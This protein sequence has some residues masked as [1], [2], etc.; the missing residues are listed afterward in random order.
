[1]YA[2]TLALLGF[3]GLASAASNLPD[4]TNCGGAYYSSD[5]IATAINAAIDDNNSGNRPDN[6]EL[7]WSAMVWC[8]AVTG[9][10]M[11]VRWWVEVPSGGVSSLA[12]R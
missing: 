9:R 1:M 3:A 11:A 12:H 8:G 6:C 10:E 4:G 2:L 7:G 5:D